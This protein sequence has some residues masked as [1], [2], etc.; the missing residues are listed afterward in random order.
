M[1][2]SG[3]HVDDRTAWAILH[4]EGIYAPVGL[5]ADGQRLQSLLMLREGLPLLEAAA[6]EEDV[7]AIRE[8]L[9]SEQGLAGL[10]R[11][12]SGPDL[13]PPLAQAGRRANDAPA[14]RLA[15]GNLAGIPGL[16]ELPGLHEDRKSVV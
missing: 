8:A 15:R 1:A 12:F 6:D 13:F 9:F 4:R 7:R 3:V 11:R 2:R 10:A 5:P 14:A 16:P